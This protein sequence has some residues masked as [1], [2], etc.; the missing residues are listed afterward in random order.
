MAFLL[1]FQQQ[2]VDATIANATALAHVTPLALPP[3]A[4]WRSRRIDLDH[5]QPGRVL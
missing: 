5:L 4:F 1:V 2:R 3:I